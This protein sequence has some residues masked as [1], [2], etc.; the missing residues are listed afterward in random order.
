MSLRQPIPLYDMRSQSSSRLLDILQSA[1]NGQKVMLVTTISTDRVSRV[2]ENSTYVE[3]GITFYPHDENQAPK[4]VKVVMPNT[5]APKMY[6][7]ALNKSIKRH[8]VLS[9]ELIS[10]Q[11]RTYT[12]INELQWLFSA[13]KEATHSQLTCSASYIHVSGGVLKAL[14]T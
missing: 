9:L 3:L 11:G 13:T 1:R 10:L 5:W 12:T 4:V 8:S 2:D 6:L 14:S 7:A